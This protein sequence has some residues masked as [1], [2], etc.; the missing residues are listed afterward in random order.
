MTWQVNVIGFVV[1]AALMLAW[2]VLRVPIQ[3][4]L[5]HRSDRRPGEDKSAPVRLVGTD[6]EDEP[7]TGEHDNIGW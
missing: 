2:T 3:K 6:E 7:T 5:R 1:G 4:W